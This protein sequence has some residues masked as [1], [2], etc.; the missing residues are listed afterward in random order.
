[1]GTQNDLVNIQEKLPFKTLIKKLTTVAFNK[2]NNPHHKIKKANKST[3]AVAII[4]T[5]NSIT[6]KTGRINYNFQ[7]KISK[8]VINQNRNIKHNHSKRPY[9]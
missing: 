7:I 4:K 9:I 2:I 6:Q 1:M 5:I 3:F 8:K